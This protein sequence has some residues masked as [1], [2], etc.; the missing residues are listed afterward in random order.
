VITAIEHD[1]ERDGSGLRQRASRPSTRWVIFRP[2]RV[3]PAP[4]LPNPVTGFVTGPEGD[5]DI[6]TDEWGRVKVH[7]HWDRS[8]PTTTAAR[9]G[10][11]P[12]G[13]H[14]SLVGHPPHALG[15][16][17]HFL[18]GD[19]DRPVVL[20]RVY[21][22]EDP[23]P[24]RLPEMKTRSALKSLTSPR[25]SRDSG[26]ITGSNEIQFD[27]CISVH[28]QAKSGSSSARRVCDVGG[29]RTWS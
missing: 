28:A 9:T 21:N 12:P 2:P 13:Q 23:F 26:E 15:G 18:E 6:H 16:A 20:G 14:R 19:P 25:E 11:R 29:I 4:V 17:V 1:F 27:E 22:A 24:Q 10:S 5:D 3:T 8:S 7:F